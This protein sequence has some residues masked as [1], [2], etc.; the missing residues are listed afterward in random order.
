VDSLIRIEGVTKR[1]GSHTALDA[2]SLAIREGELFC[3]LGPSG[4]GK[5]TLLRLIAGFETPDSGRV[6]LGGNDLA[7][8]PPHRRPVNMMFQSYALFPHLSV[9][10]NVGFGLRQEGLPRREI[11]ARVDE[12]L[13]LVQLDGLGARY[14]EQISGGQRQRVALARALARR[15]RLLLL[16]EPLAA[17]D[18]KLREQTRYELAQLRR[19]LGTTFLVVTHD[20]DEAMTMADRIAVMQHGRLAQVGSPREVYETPASRFVA[21]FIGDA[22]L[23]EGHVAAASDGMAEVRTRAAGTP[24]HVRHAGPLSPGQA[25][26]VAVRPEKLAIN[27]GGEATAAGNALSGVVSDIGYLGDLTLYRVTLPSGD[28]VRASHANARRGDIP[29]RLGDKVR[30]AFAPD[31]AVVLTA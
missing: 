24:L 18:R 11:A 25:I 29:A 2:L 21:S 13:A 19:R 20:Q 30:L 6:L 4:C 23:F 31:D 1:F 9:A 26:A 8:V 7:G 22:T 16:D 17:L 14:P 15:P 3:L 5:S 12:M 10:G 27:R 28:I